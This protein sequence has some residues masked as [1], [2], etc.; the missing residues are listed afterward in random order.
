[1]KG[2]EGE[3][4][5]RVGKERERERGR[6][7]RTNED[8]DQSNENDSQTPSEVTTA[9]E[10]EGLTS[11][12]GVEGEESDG[13]ESVEE[14]WDENGPVT[15]REGEKQTMEGRDRRQRRRQIE[16][17]KSRKRKSTKNLPEGVSRHDHLPQSKLGSKGRAGGSKGRGEEE[18]SSTAKAER[19][20]A[21][22]SLLSISLPSSLL[23]L[24]SRLMIRRS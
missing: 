8:S 3:G 2:G 22:I 7:R 19:T 18:V 23:L 13:G 9:G 20:R 5:D 4:S 6:G 10:T 24:L 14:S 15:V 12:D 21:P 16:N 11:E 1:M 17:R